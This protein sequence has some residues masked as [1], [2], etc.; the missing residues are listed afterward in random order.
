MKKHLSNT[1]IKMETTHQLLAHV[2]NL[3]E[4]RGGCNSITD[5]RKFDRKDSPFILVDSAEM[6]LS[7]LM[8][9][10]RT[11]DAA[12]LYI[13][14]G[15]V[16][17]AHDQ[18]TY[19]L[20]EGML[21]LKLPKVT[22]QLLSFSEDCHFKIF[23]YAPQFAIA[24]GMPTRHFETITVMA[25]NNP[26][27]I[28]DTL[29]AATVAVLF[30]LLQKK[31][32]SDEKAQSHDETIQHVFSLLILEIVAS[33]KR[34]LVDNPCHYSRKV[35]LTFQFLK[36]VREHIK[37]QRSVTFFADL[38]YVTPKHLSICV[39]EITGKNCGEI[40]GEMVVTE[41]KALLHNPEL[42][43]GHVADELQFSDQFFFSKYFKKRTG[44]SP[45][46]YRMAG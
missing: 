25:S 32:S 40:I 24:G 34:K 22:V 23:C 41:A 17:L 12:M 37:A 35:Y 18:K 36:L 21:L 43:I 16:T 28:L 10:A 27:L 9:A 11:D 7:S 4:A 19:I 42:T 6:E 45:L 5:T 33:I 38:L 46:H 14:K 39:K 2:G 29:T 31:G 13:D 30:W 44:M 20:S 1:S 15:E 8:S 26:V 3:H